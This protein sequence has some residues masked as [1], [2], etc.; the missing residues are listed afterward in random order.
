MSLHSECSMRWNT[1]WR[2]KDI[3]PT[4]LL[5]FFISLCFFAPPLNFQLNPKVSFY[6]CW[7]FFTQSF[8]PLPVRKTVF[9]LTT[10]H[11]S[12][13]DPTTKEE[14]K[15]C[16]QKSVSFFRFAFFDRCCRFVSCGEGRKGVC[17]HSATATQLS[18]WGGWRQARPSSFLFLHFNW[19]VFEV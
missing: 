16:T 18:T 10:K 14:R 11:P 2:E 1:Q 5:L 3:I 4:C 12:S 6:L 7:P 15:R 19:L 17:W 9:T 8:Y 13:Q